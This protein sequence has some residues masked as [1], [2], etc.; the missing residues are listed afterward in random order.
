MKTSTIILIIGAGVIVFA[1][2]NKRAM[3][4]GA[5]LQND[6]L[7]PKVTVLSNGKPYS[8]DSTYNDAGF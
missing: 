6:V 4:M 5:K 8:A 3:T 7:K 2:L 1:M